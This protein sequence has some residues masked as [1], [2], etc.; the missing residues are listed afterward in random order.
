MSF[1][2]FFF[3]FLYIFSLNVS[4]QRI[5]KVTAEYV[6]HVPENLSLEEAKRIALERAKIQAIAD[7]FGTIV[8]QS[9]F[10]N[11]VN[12]NGKSDV[13][14][15]S[16]GGSEVKGEWIE[17]IG[18]PEYAIAYENGMLVISVSVSGRIREVVNAKV[19]FTARI[20]CNGTD[21][22]YERSDFRNGDDLY[23]YFQ[24]P[25]NG[26]LVVYL[27]DHFQN[28]FCL[29]PYRR[30]NSGVFEVSANTPY[31]LFSKNEAVGSIKMLTDEYVMT[32]L[33]EKEFNRVYIVFSPNRFTKALDKKQY[34]KE[35]FP[36]ELSAEDFQRWLIDCRKHDKEMSVEVKD[37][38][39]SK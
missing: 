6:Y 23:L 24:T 19:N 34:N 8:S 32:S 11:V 37:I 17:T 15:L 16:L 12:R 31:I 21:L 30:Q 27:V 5:E 22:K 28:T 14:F 18:K 9:N 2:L 36:Y 1:R 13:D 10:T 33:K 35:I 4:G 20:L 29:L 7:A 38:T 39:I 26:Y 25:V 3:G